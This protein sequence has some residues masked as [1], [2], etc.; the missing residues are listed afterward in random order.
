MDLQA[1]FSEPRIW[2]AIAILTFFA[3]AGRGIWGFATRVLDQRGEIIRAELDEAAALRA[4]AEAMLLEA[5]VRR[6]AALKEAAELLASAR[7]EA[8]RLTEDARIDAAASAKRREKM[9]LDRIAAA[10][11]AA[12][13]DVRNQAAL[14]ATQAAEVIIREGLPPASATGLV[15]SAID[16]LPKALATP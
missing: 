4:E 1:I 9:A 10:E 3:L 5:S 12:I 2:V 11:K 16:A 6:D 7:T 8:A 13:T 15:R 14:I